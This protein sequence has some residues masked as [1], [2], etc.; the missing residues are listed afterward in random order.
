MDCDDIRG[1]FSEYYDGGESDE[2]VSEHLAGCSVCASEYEEYRRL[3]DELQNLPVS[4][5]PFGFHENLMA[6]VRNY[7]EKNRQAA[8]R[9]VYKRFAFAAA[10]VLWAVVWISGGLLINDANRIHDGL[11][12]EPIMPAGFDLP[13]EFSDELILPA[14]FEDFPPMARGFA[15]PESFAMPG[16]IEPFE[17]AAF[18]IEPVPFD[19]MTFDG[20]PIG[21]FFVGFEY[22]EP[23]PGPTLGGMS[24]RTWLFFLIGALPLAAG[25]I[26][27]LIKIQNRKTR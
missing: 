26:V 8:R 11:P 23:P 25:L 3:I 5:P 22:P 27:I 1:L 17:P 4:E 15:E 9:L 2:D 16:N 13:I 20:E 18:D 10:A 6:G 21:M 24:V 19:L 14:E 12:V 7:A